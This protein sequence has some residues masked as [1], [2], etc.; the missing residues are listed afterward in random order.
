VRR[1]FTSHP[2]DP[3]ADAESH[4]VESRR[5]ADAHRSEDQCAAREGSRTSRSTAECESRQDL[6]VADARLKARAVSTYPDPTNTRLNERTVESLRSER[7]YAKIAARQQAQSDRLLIAGVLLAVLKRHGVSHD[8]FGMMIGVTAK[9]VFK[10]LRAE[11][12]I[13]MHV[14]LRMESEMRDELIDEVAKA[15]GSA[16]VASPERLLARIERD[17]D[18]DALEALEDAAREVGRRMRRGR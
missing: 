16:S 18:F 8:R 2:I 4:R 17:R 15:S 12:S 11:V 7:G 1:S 13:P 9:A 14:L 5:A 10:M 3:R 6:Y